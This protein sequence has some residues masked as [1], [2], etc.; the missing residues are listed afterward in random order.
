MRR[1]FIIFSLLLAALPL[2]AV[3]QRGIVRTIARPDSKGEPLSGVVMRVRGSHNAIESLADGSFSLN[4]SSLSNGDPFVISSI[5]LSGYELADKQLIGRPIACSETVPIEILMVNR[6]ALQQE[7]DRIARKARQN[8]EIYYEK[9]V[10]EFEQLLQ[11]GKLRQEEYEQQLALL[12]QKYEQ[13]EPLLELMADKY[14]RTDL[15]QLSDIDV[16]INSAIENGNLDEAERLIHS[17]GDFL[18]REQQ[19]ARADAQNAEARE[20][21]EAMQQRLKQSEELVRKQRE[22]LQ[23]DY[24]NLYTIHLTRF[25][26]DSAAHYLCLRANLDTTD[27]TLQTETGQFLGNIIAD[28]QKALIY[29]HRAERQAQPQ[30]LQLAVAQ[31]ELA[32]T[33]QY[34]H[35]LEKAGQYY[36]LS[37][38]I[39]RQTSAKDHPEDVAET[40][41]NLSDL[42]REQKDYKQALNCAQQALDIWTRHYGRLNIRVAAAESN[43]GMIYLEQQKLK[44]AKQHFQKSIDITTQLSSNNDRQL[45]S[46]YNNIATVYF[47]E[48]DFDLAKQYFD[49]AYTLFKKSLGAS[50]PL[51]TQ[52]GINLQV[53]RQ[54]KLKQQ[55]Q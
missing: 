49:K 31:H 55:K 34:L 54:A 18:S 30:S 33:Y 27:V 42:Y 23:N 5:V 25:R 7:K 13:F 14:A 11:Q 24:Y 26:H 4:L 46:F 8:V 10:A 44:Q 22:N 3:T 39:R 28:Y 32:Q 48:S 50:H 47:Y 43:I 35:N 20:Q 19:I 52:T 53:V 45:A 2:Q 36:L 16:H 6:E 37:L 17:K 29:L 41:N 40:L 21:L 9:R 12:E 15:S 51:T 38:D 1:H